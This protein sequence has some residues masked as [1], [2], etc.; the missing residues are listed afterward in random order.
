MQS[1]AAG[2]IVM[3]PTST[4]PSTDN[5]SPPKHAKASPWA[6]FG[7]ASFT[8]LWIATVVSNVGT[9]MHDVG[10][11]WLMTELDPSPSVV[12]MVQAATTLPVF[13]FALLAGAVADIVDRR[14]LLILVNLLMGAVATGLAVVVHLEVMTPWLLI[15]F[16]FAMGTGAAFVAPAWQAIVPKL[17]DRK[18]LSSA[19]A[20][21]SMGINVSR[22]IG[23]ALAGFLIVSVGIAMPFA[24]NTLSFVGIVIALIWWRSP[25]S[26]A[27]T[28]PREHVGEAIRA[29]LRYAI[30]SGPVRATLVRA[31]FF[32]IFASAYW[33]MLPLIARDVLAGGATLYGL[34]LASVG[35]GAVLGALILPSIRARFG[36]NGTVAL[37]TL[38]TAIAMASFALPPQAGLAA[39]AS[40]LAGV[41]WIAVLSSLHVSAQTALPDWVRARGLSVFLTIFFGAMA[42]GS[43]IW[44]QV[45]SRLS[46]EMALLIAAGGAVAF[47]PLTWAAKLGQGEALNLAPSSHWPEPVLSEGADDT[48]GPVMIQITYHVGV[49][50]HPAFE[51]LMVRMGQA[52]RRSGAYRW[53]LMQDAETPDRFVET[54]FEPSWADHLRHHGRVTESDRA[55]QDQVKA[56]TSNEPSVSHYLTRRPKT[57]TPVSKGDLQ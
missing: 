14:K 37:G 16:T 49:D 12:A 34:L 6:P 26:P 51:T 29:G 22:A 57:Q 32:F 35:A 45:A 56:L 41:S 30:N 3:T 53:S 11:G 18:D 7:Y 5:T 2:S 23:P 39:A 9:W 43:L 46:I 24:L 27:A 47:V 1:V 20:L 40:A 10:A 54:W 36:A 31:A 48:S 52:R 42:A 4:A 28:L 50:D 25:A 55:L 44:G 33:A 19:I 8:V 38:G 21:N 17:V 15:A 13:L